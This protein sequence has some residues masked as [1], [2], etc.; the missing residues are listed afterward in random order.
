MKNIDKV[1]VYG[2]LRYGMYNY[3]K[4][5]KNKVKKRQL[6]T[7]KGELYHLA[8]KGYPAIQDGEDN[9]IGE[10]YEFYDFDK[11]IKELDELEDYYPNNIMDSY[12][13]REVTDVKL[14]NDEVILAY[15]YKRNSNSEFNINDDL[16]R[17]YDGDWKSYILNNSDN[18]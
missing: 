1:F 18:I 17:I 7:I 15:V 2:S 8:N 10:V 9:I 14:E 11:V 4:L 12:Y 5:L 6:G 16:I 3:E 13:F